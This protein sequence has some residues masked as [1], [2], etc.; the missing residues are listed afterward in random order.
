M[1]EL[2]PIIVKSTPLSINKALR[3]VNNRARGIPEE[4]PNRKITIISFLKN[5]FIQFAIKSIDL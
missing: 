1:M 2:N 4:I 3:V 5:N